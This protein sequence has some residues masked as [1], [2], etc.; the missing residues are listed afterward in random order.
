[1]RLVFFLIL[2]SAS[3][4]AQ[5]LHLKVNAHEVEMEV[6]MLYIGEVSKYGDITYELYDLSAQSS[7]DLPYTSS[8]VLGV[9]STSQVISSFEGI[10]DPLQGMYWTWQNGYI[11]VKM[12]GKYLGEDFAY[13]LGG[14]R[15]PFVCYHIIELAELNLLT[16]DLDA[17]FESLPS[18]ISRHIMS[19]GSE[20]KTVF[21]TFVSNVL[22]D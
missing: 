22:L 16:I 17:F 19:P 12:E 3:L 9:D 8:M 14:F 20:A 4:T 21:D 5:N 1:M 11:A 2:I 7:L 13:H 10:F 18:D 6:F 15:E